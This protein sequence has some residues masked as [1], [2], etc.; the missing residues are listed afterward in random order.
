MF[1]G[2]GDQCFV[3]SDPA[4]QG[5]DPVLEAGASK[6]LAFQS[7]LQCGARSLREQTAQVAVTALGDHAEARLSAGAVLSR[8]KPHPRG[9]LAAVL[10]IARIGYR[11]SSAITP[12]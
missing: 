11:G 5:D 4:V 12:L 1:V 7:D 6:W 9:Q 10:E 3:I 2:Y 8:D